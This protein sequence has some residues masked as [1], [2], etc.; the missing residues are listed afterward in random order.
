VVAGAIGAPLRYLLDGA[1]GRRTTGAFPRGILLINV[2]GSFLLGL[3]TGLGLHHGLGRTPRIVIG[4]GFCG[5]F[6]TFSTFTYETVRL[7]EEGDVVDAA[8]NVGLTLVVGGMAAA[9]GLAI[10]AVV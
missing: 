9:L 7:I 3:V 5:A 10:P 2:S 8:A 4:T 1:V 6:T